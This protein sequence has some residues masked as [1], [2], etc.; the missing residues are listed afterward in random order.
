[1]STDLCPGPDLLLQ[2]EHG[3][4]DD[5]EPSPGEREGVNPSPTTA[6]GSRGEWEGVNASPT[7]AEGSPSTAEGSRGEGARL[8]RHVAGCATCQAA[9]A[10]VL[11]ALAAPALPAP[12]AKVL[13]GVR[14][15][16]AAR[17]A[18]GAAR[19][20]LQDAVRLACTYCKDRLLAPETVYCAL[21]LAP[22]HGECFVDH[23]RC[24]AGGCEG[25]EVVRSRSATDVL[26][27]A[28]R[29]RGSGLR[30]WRGPITLAALAGGSVLAVVAAVDVK[31]ESMRWEA[32]RDEAVAV[33]RE[34]GAYRLQQQGA[35]TPAA[36][37]G[38]VVERYDVTALLDP[39]LAPLT[40]AP[41]V[42]DLRFAELTGSVE[43]VVRVGDTLYGIASDHG[44][45]WRE[46]LE[47]NRLY[48][49]GALRV[50][51]RLRLPDAA[52]A[53]LDLPLEIPGQRP[54]PPWGLRAQLSPRELLERVRSEPFLEWDAP[55]QV[56]LAGG[57]LVVSHTPEAQRLVG[58]LLGR[59]GIE[60]LPP[61][62]PWHRAWPRACRGPAYWRAWDSW[63]LLQDVP[64][65]LP[66]GEL[67]PNQ[68]LVA[69]ARSTGVPT[70]VYGEV[71]EWSPGW[72]APRTFES[73]QAMELLDEL[74]RTS[75]AVWDVDRD[76]VLLRPARVEPLERR[77]AWASRQS[78]EAS[79]PTL[80]DRD[81][82]RL[83]RLRRQ[84]ISGWVDG[85]TLAQL[86][87]ILE[88][89][90]QAY[91]VVNDE[92]LTSGVRV[93]LP[94]GVSLERA[95]ELLWREAGVVGT[96]SVLEPGGPLVISLTALGPGAVGSAY[97]A[98]GEPVL[99]TWPAEPPALRRAL[100][101]A[102]GELE[103]AMDAL[104]DRGLI[105]AQD[106]EAPEGSSL[107]ELR[108]QAVEAATT[109]LD[110][111]VV[112]LRSLT[113]RLESRP[114]GVARGTWPP[115][116]QLDA[117]WREHLG[118]TCD[119][120]RRDRGQ[121][122][123][124]ADA[125]LASLVAALGHDQAVVEALNRLLGGEPWRALFPEGYGWWE[126]DSLR[127]LTARAE[128]GLRALEALRVVLT[129]GLEVAEVLAGGDLEQANAVVAAARSQGVEQHWELALHLG[130]LA[131]A[132]SEASGPLRLG[133]RSEAG[134][135]VVYCDGVALNEPGALDAPTAELA[136][137]NLEVLLHTQLRALG[138]PQ[139]VEVVLSTDPEVT[140]GTVLRLVSVITQAGVTQISFV[141]Q[142]PDLGEV[143]RGR[144]EAEPAQH[145]YRVAQ[146]AFREYRYH[147]ARRHLEQVLELDPGNG[148]AEEL[149]Y[150]VRL[151]LGEDAP[152]F[153]ER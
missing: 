82:E 34:L 81:R 101:E 61:D 115:R 38:H 114:P 84:T 79:A 125:P 112:G 58:H 47:L 13:A 128:R 85:A 10:R 127:E 120:W 135:T 33:E 17:R 15:G 57:T 60:N 139:Q 26:P 3:L 63:L 1:V 150:R 153:R 113:S 4:F 53:P 109:H 40:P 122:V 42:P 5:D 95:F 105:D 140:Y 124:R 136:W 152:R 59:L 89:S 123:R 49:V 45:D 111:V 99:S 117:T 130:G 88:D 86:A 74:A 11:G 14:A 119:C 142:P 68:V 76:G 100:D 126:Q 87:S 67:T 75:G 18:A 7:T 2:L 107:L 48:E 39:D 121:E 19:S 54:E 77:L 83:G 35:E 133:V 80:S 56:E 132:E 62:G 144:R 66:R 90:T 22:H 110:D 16:I 94:Y 51:Q 141:A 6:E 131:P 69:V 97:A 21:C 50:G 25:F 8:R 116:D 64:L 138:D 55:A 44:V 30:R 104:A 65:V 46:L 32:I 147:E 149:L 12:P 92:D 27:G 96:F 20:P 36:Q 9:Q 134:A 23:G 52:V 70:R 103:Q 102:V 91:V 31:E 29:R 108:L 71:G 98:L 145:H 137:V 78:L 143:L 28:G 43:Y 73:S 37:P 151:L 118:R 148:P 106:A 72:D 93:L 24:A 146:A 41:P 129:P